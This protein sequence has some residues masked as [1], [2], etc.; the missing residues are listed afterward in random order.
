MDALVCLAKYKTLTISGF[1]HKLRNR[2]ASESY[3][4]S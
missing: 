2:L 1:S 4:K 3:K